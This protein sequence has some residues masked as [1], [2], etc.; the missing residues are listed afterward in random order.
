MINLRSA[1]LNKIFVQIKKHIQFL[2]N[3]LKH[4][5]ILLII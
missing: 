4:N 5:K 3:K 2:K 1:Y